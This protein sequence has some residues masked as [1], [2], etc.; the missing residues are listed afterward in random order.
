YFQSDVQRV[1]HNMASVTSNQY[2]T[3]VHPLFPIIAH[4]IYVGV[5]KALR[6]DVVHNFGAGLLASRIVSSIVAAVTMAAMFAL[7][8]IVSLR[9]L[10]AV[11]F[12]L[13]GAVCSFSVF[14]FSVP[15]CYPW[16]ALSVLIALIVVAVDCRRPLSAWWYWLA[17]GL[18]LAF[19]TTNW[20]VGWLALFSKY[21]WRRVLQWSINIFFV[22]TVLWSV[23]RLI[24]RSSRYFTEIGEER[25]Y[26][27]N[28]DSGGPRG[29]A[30]SF[31][32]HTVVMPKLVYLPGDR[33]DALNKINMTT[34][35]SGIGSTGL[36]GHVAAVAWA[37]LLIAGLYGWLTIPDFWTWKV[38]LLLSLLGQLTLHLLY[39]DETFLYA[40]H[41]GPM[42]IALAALGARTPLRPAVLGLAG[43]TIVCCAWNN[44]AVF[45]ETMAFIPTT[46]HRVVIHPVPLHHEE[47]LPTTMPAPAPMGYER[48][49]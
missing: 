25:K 20:M 28:R 44:L 11:I 40:A 42:L 41:F 43:V 10:D 36:V 2:R 49:P 9:R 1:Y 23:Q 3:K 19:T 46:R 39:G 16:G 27:M 30:R 26:V 33:P 15:E 45:R 4:P 48:L 21:P 8:R 31:F 18:T 12:C 47:P 34:Q 37:L 7:L 5:V 17:S 22:V 24:F 35:L 38:V 29:V 13:L 32:Y 14:W 6:L